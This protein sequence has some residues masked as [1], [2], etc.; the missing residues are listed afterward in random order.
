MLNRRVLTTFLIL[1]IG[2]SLV[3]CSEGK[4][5][6]CNQLIEIAN[7]AASNVES[8]TNNSSPDDPEA[9]LSIAETA[10]EAAR[11]LEDVEITDS[12]LEDYKQQFISLYVETSLAT[13]QLV[14]AV[15]A[16]DAE[17]AEAAYG[18]L[19]EATEKEAPLVDDVNAY[20]GGA[21]QNQ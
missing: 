7:Q 14:E 13:Q 12:T 8:V 10:D 19:E 17:E 11:S 5:S 3:S 2:V 20:C 18:R 1:S 15:Q 16:Q 21:A 9:F 4:V 6:Q